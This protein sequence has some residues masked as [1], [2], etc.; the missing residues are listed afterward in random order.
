[1]LEK[2]KN[3]LS[4]N[5]VDLPKGT[6]LLRTSSW[7]VLNPNEQGYVEGKKMA[8]RTDEAGEITVVDLD[9][10]NKHGHVSKEEHWEMARNGQV[11]GDCIGEP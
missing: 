1:M 5:G 4:R 8:A 6:K 2:L 7:R 9:T 3:R 11:S 10:Y